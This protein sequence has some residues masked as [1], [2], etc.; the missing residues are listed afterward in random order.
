MA[1]AASCLPELSMTNL[2]HLQRAP[3]KRLSDARLME[4]P[5][6]H[7]RIPGIQ[8]RFAM[9][10][11]DRH[12][13]PYLGE[14]WC[15]VFMLLKGHLCLQDSA[16]TWR[17]LDMAAIGRGILFLRS[18][19]YGY[20]W[21]QPRHSL[22]PSTLGAIIV[23]LS[24][25]LQNKRRSWSSDITIIKGLQD[26]SEQGPMF[27]MICQNSK[28]LLLEVLYLA[29]GRCILDGGDRLLL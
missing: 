25:S 3:S 27:R 10:M 24:H 29:D 15:L 9:E 28:L 22:C 23:A 1:A 20:V 11:K 13:P 12:C 4:E 17:L 21:R 18:Q 6:P 8:M 5:M 19:G 26:V 14:D 7:P 2:S 16:I